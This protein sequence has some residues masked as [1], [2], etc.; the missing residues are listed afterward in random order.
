MGG[1]YK[2]LS[3]LSREGPSTRDE[4]RSR[5][6]LGRSSF[7]ERVRDCI[8]N[9]WIQVTDG[10]SAGKRISSYSITELGQDKLVE[11][12]GIGITVTLPK[13]EIPVRVEFRREEDAR[14]YTKKHVKGGHEP[15]VETRGTH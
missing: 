10:I 5:T 8:E 9:E 14:F 12:A 13:R 15:W 11:S 1:I 7:Y 6:G 2:I 3:W 4:L